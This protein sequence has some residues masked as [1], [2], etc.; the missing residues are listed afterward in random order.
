[1]CHAK[2]YQTSIVRAVV[3]SRNSTSH[4]FTRLSSDHALSED[5][6][7]PV[8]LPLGDSL[9]HSG[10]YIGGSSSTSA[11]TRPASS[12]NLN[13]PA[14][15]VGLGCLPPNAPAGAS[16][17]GFW[18]VKAAAICALLCDGPT[19]G[20]IGGDAKADGAKCG[21]VNMD[22]EPSS[23]SGRWGAVD[24]PVLLLRECTKFGG[25]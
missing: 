10:L 17:S 24:D 18:A 7:R 11:S 5:L 4:A 15:A 9:S 22:G 8:I 2:A 20:D 21:N 6:L 25:A 3:K 13:P 23:S 14:G 16:R 19:P 12:C 1:M